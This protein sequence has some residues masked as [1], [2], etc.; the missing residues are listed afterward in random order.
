MG[1]GHGWTRCKR[2][3]RRARGQGGWKFF[4]RSARPCIPPLLGQ[5]GPRGKGW[6]HLSQIHSPG[7]QNLPASRFLRALERQSGCVPV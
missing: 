1:L 7:A 2:S 4:V 5:W 6:G 3:G